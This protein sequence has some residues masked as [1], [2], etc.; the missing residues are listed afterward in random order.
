MSPNLYDPRRVLVILV[1]AV[2]ATR[3]NAHFGSCED[4]STSCAK[5]K[6]WGFC[7]TNL[8]FMAFNCPVTCN[9]CLDPGCFDRNHHCSLWA[10]RGLCRVRRDIQQTCPHS[11][12]MCKIPD[13]LT[14]SPTAKSITMPDFGCGKPVVTPGAAAGRRKRQIIFPNELSG[15]RGM[16]VR[17][18]P[19]GTAAIAGGSTR[20]MATGVVN[21]NETFCGA[22]LIHERYLLTAAHCVLDPDRPVR[23]VRLGELDFS[24]DNEEFSKPVDYRV[25][26]ITVH[27]EF[28]PN[29][30]ERYNDLALIETVDNV[31]FNDVVYPFCLSGTRPANDATVTGSGFGFTNNTNRPTHVQEAILKVVDSRRCEELYNN[32]GLGQTLRALYPQSIQ[33]RDVI[34]AAFPGRDACEG[35]SGGPLFQ[36]VDGRRFLVGVIAQGI[37][38]RG[39]GVASLPGFYVSV[40][41]HTDFIDSVIYSE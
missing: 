15:V 40:A 8:Q 28:K 20:P 23:T 17:N 30:L 10:R 25:K 37:S 9:I 6:A 22:T 38:C 4:H 39:N 26:L 11:C 1:L 3:T 7:E 14:A 33:G 2:L 12:N 32:E 21:V 35:D 19:R 18:V 34:C 27:P 5:W 31:Q 24:R 36:D 29:S 16:P 13:F 41:D